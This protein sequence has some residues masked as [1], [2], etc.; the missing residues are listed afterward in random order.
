M[1]VTIVVLFVLCWLPLHTFFLV[2]HFTSGIDEKAPALILTYYL[3]HWVAMSNSF[4]N[5]IVYCSLNDSFR[6]SL[7]FSYFTMIEMRSAK[8]TFFKGLFCWRRSRHFVWS[9]YEQKHEYTEKT[10]LFGHVTTY[11][12]T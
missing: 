7:N 6:V 9:H 8:K 1:L 10:Y 12:I 5:P 2:L 4:V 3:C 11:H